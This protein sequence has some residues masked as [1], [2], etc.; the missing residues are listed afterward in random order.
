[1]IF[2]DPGGVVYFTDLHF[3]H[4]TWRGRGMTVGMVARCPDN[5]T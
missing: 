2:S 5:S 3:Q 4:S 1:M